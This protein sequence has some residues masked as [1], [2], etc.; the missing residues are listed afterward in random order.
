[1]Y[2]KTESKMVG[3]LDSQKRAAEAREQRIRERDESTEETLPDGSVL[4]RSVEYKTVTFE[5]GVTKRVKHVVRYWI[6]AYAVK[7]ARLR[8]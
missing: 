7:H 1:V 5:D 3:A 4:G 8:G 2:N 6:S